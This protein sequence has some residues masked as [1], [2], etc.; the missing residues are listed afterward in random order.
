MTWTPVSIL[1]NLRAAN[2][3]DGKVIALAGVSDPRV[4][5]ICA[6]SPKFASLLAQFTDAFHVR[7]DPVVLIARDDTIGRLSGEAFLSFRDLVAISVIPISRALN[8]VY[9]N[10]DRITFSNSFWLYPWM[11]NTQTQHLTTSTPALA[12]FHVVE[13]FLGQS[14]P[15]LSV[16][17]V[18]DLDE[19]L[20]DVLMSRW[21]RFYLG[22]RPRWADRALFRSLNMAFQAASLPGGVGVT[23]FDLGRNIALWVSALEILSHPRTNKADLFTVYPLFEK[24]VYCDR[25]VGRRQYAAYVGKKKKRAAPAMQRT[26]HPRR[27]LPCWIYGRLYDARNHFLHG[28]PVSLKLLSPTKGSGEGLFWL[29]APLYRLALG[30]FLN[31]SVEKDLPYWLSSKYDGNQKLQKKRRAHDRQH[32]IERSLLRIRKSRTPPR[33]SRR[34]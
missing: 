30:S 14:T 9:R 22:K 8:T 5:A 16:V 13:Q 15:E 21:H 29:A 7:L 4:Q 3:I 26:K 24:L 28:N 18:R 31:L 11:L 27:P 1:P 2:P 32:M 12:A 17:D 20:F 34:P 25:N 23:L 33:T 19:P 6:A 10:G